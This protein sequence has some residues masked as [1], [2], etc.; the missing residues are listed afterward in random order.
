MPRK[1]VTSEAEMPKYEHD[2]PNFTAAPLPEYQ[3]VTRGSHRSFS[4][5][6]LNPALLVQECIN[7]GQDN[8]PNRV[9]E[10]RRT[11]RGYIA[12]VNL[13]RWTDEPQWQWCSMSEQ[14]V[15]QGR[16]NA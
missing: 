15:E 2:N 8:L 9:S 16:M 7:R 6:E 5:T 13:E 1:K 3:P 12:R 14:E 11:E 10:W 4:F